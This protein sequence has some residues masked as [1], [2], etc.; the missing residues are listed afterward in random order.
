MNVIASAWQ[1]PNPYPLAQM[2]RNDNVFSEF[3]LHKEFSRKNGLQV[4][5][6]G[7]SNETSYGELHLLA[8]TY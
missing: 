4:R 2:S 8:D 6:I 5:H 1:K 7:V 3:M